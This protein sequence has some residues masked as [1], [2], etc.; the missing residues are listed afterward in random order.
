MNCKWILALLVTAS[1][2]AADI[3]SPPWEKSPLIA[4]R[5]LFRENCAVCHDIDKDQKHTRKLG[6]SLNHLFKNEKLPLSHGKPSRPYVMVRIKFG[7]ALM[8]AFRAQLND[9]QINT[10]IDY[11]TSK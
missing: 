3:K 7:G 6:P 4:G 2:S 5:D 1:L 10:L 11:I 8:P 9:S